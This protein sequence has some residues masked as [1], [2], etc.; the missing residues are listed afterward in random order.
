MGKRQIVYKAG[1]IRGNSD[2]IDKEVNL[3]TIEDR[4]WHG[5]IV[6]V[7]QSEVILRDARSGKHKFPLDQIDKIYRDI[8]TDY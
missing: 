7:N 8:V 5:R 4:V 2:L 3:I 1:Q 6:S